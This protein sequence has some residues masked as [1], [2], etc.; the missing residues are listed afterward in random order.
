[1]GEQYLKFDQQWGGGPEGV[2][3]RFSGGSPYD[4]ARASDDLSQLDEDTR[5]KVAKY[6]EK[7]QDEIN[8]Q[9]EAKEPGLNYAR[10]GN[11]SQQQADKFLPQDIG[12][13]GIHPA[14]GMHDYDQPPQNSANNDPFSH[15]VS[16][17]GSGDQWPVRSR[18]GNRGTFARGG[19]MN[20]N[21]YAN[22][23][24]PG[25]P[26]SISVKHRAAPRITRAWEGKPRVGKLHVAAPHSGEGLVMYIHLGPVGMQF[27]SNTVAAES[28]S[29][30]WLNVA[31]R[32]TP[33]MPA[34]NPLQSGPSPTM[35]PQGTCGLPFQPRRR[36]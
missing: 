34:T 11:V 21:P 17:R 35:L 12:S 27:R 25:L 19:A 36:L 33:H 5:E 7:A 23:A 1:M 24:D 28:M 4:I 30:A 2:S 22:P 32:V 16:A 6:A 31:Y 18:R 9:L 10:G 8:D 29:S 13:N 14:E 26:P 15:G 3:Q 20:K